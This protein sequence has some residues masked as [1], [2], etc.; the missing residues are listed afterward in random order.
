MSACPCR[1]VTCCSNML[2]HSSHGMRSMTALLED[3]AVALP[4]TTLGQGDD[5]EG[6][7]HLFDSSLDRGAGGTAFITCREETTER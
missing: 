2:A 1:V 6:D 3:M 7:T 4:A 5:E